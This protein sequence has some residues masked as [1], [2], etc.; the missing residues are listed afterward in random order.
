MCYVKNAFPLFCRRKAAYFS[1]K[2]D[3]VF[4]DSLEHLPEMQRVLEAST[5]ITIDVEWRPN[6]FTAHISAPSTPVASGAADME[7]APSG[8]SSPHSPLANTDGAVST[9]SEGLFRTVAVLHV[10]QGR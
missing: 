8:A 9:L 3:T 2:M 1:C 5:F 6:S 7:A 4:V 10:N